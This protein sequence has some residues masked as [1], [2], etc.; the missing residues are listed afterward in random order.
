MLFDG[1]TL[2]GWRVARGGFFQEGGSVR[3]EDGCL[4]LDAAGDLAAGVAYEGRIPRLGYEVTF[5]MMRVDGEG[6]A[7][8]LAFPIG[9]QSCAWS[10]GNVVQSCG[11]DVV[12]GKGDREPENPTYRMYD[13]INGQWYP[14]R[15]RVERDRVQAWI[16]DERV[17]DFAPEGHQLELWG[18][19]AAL[20]PLGF[21]AARFTRA[22]VRDIRLQRL[23]P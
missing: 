12:D 8:S 3:V 5:K 17:V 2:K 4:V 23:K 16:G 6:N 14:C 11:L 20:R 18:A 22:K 7:G 1:E 10:I 19:Y 21:Y 15:L 9:D 13:F